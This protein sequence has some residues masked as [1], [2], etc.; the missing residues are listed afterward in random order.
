M[1][2]LEELYIKCITMT[3][4]EKWESPQYFKKQINKAGRAIAK[5]EYGE[6]LKILHNWRA[7]HAYPLQRTYEQLKSL[8]PTKN[9]VQRLKRMESIVDKLERFPTMRL[10][11]MQD[12]GGC[13]IIVD[14]VE[15]VYQTVEVCKEHL[16]GL[17]LLRETDY[18]K[19]PRSSGYR[20]YHMIYEYKEGDC[21]GIFLEIQ[22]RTKVQHSWATSVE[23]LGNGMGENYK[24]GRGSE[25]MK[26]FLF[27]TSSILAKQEGTNGCE[28][29]PSALIEEL[30]RIEDS[31][32]IL[33]LAKGITI[34]ESTDTLERGDDLFYVVITDVK[35][36]TVKIKTFEQTQVMAAIT[37]YNSLE[38]RVKGDEVVMVSAKS[39]QALREAYP[40]Y[41]YDMR[42]F[43]EFF[44]K[45]LNNYHHKEKG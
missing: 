44:Q 4:T 31:C 42:D 13:R 6:S 12:L 45:L 2:E 21:N 40:N 15:E 10:S 16:S 9:V 5:G 23:I 14:S 18:M 39:M 8:F 17:T 35:S 29:N 11:S 33:R 41:F 37:F 34:L 32:G 19:E 36:G 22:V 38:Q 43:T 28:E 3:N 7:S 30:A 25:E 1:Q 20:S 27:I 26:R 24:S